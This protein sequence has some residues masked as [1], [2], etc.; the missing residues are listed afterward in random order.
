MAVEWAGRGRI[1]QRPSRLN[2]NSWSV[3]RPT[4]S[5]FLLSFSAQERPSGPKCSA[6]FS[7]ISY[8][9][10][11]LA[12][13]SVIHNSRPW[14]SSARSTRKGQGNFESTEAGGSHSKL[15]K[16]ARYAPQSLTWPKLPAAAE[17]VV[18]RA[19][20]FPEYPRLVSYLVLSK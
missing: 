17:G 4:W 18:P 15:L 20:E 19:P 3:S 11:S 1:S 2:L 10:Q 8:L 16:R 14:P 7:L 6:T 13:D 5:L 9:A 12:R